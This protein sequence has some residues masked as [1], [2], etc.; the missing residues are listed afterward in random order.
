MGEAWGKYMISLR[1]SQEKLSCCTFG[2]HRRY[3]I[4]MLDCSKNRVLWELL[5]T[6]FGVTWVLSFSV[7]ETLLG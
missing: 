2:V 5:F 6:L 3:T 7:R 4:V 1:L